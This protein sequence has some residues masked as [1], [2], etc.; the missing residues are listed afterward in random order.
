MFVLGFLL[1][2]NAQSTISGQNNVLSGPILASEPVGGG[3]ILFQDMTTGRTWGLWTPVPTYDVFPT[4]WSSDGCNIVILNRR[5]GEWGTLSIVNMI[6]SMFPELPDQLNIVSTP[7]WH[8]D[9]QHLTLTVQDSVDDSVEILL[10][11]PVTQSIDVLYSSEERVNPL[12]W[13]SPTELLSSSVD[14]WFVWNSVNGQNTSFGTALFPRN[15]I[16]AEDASFMRSQQRS[17]NF[18][19]VTT[20]YTIRSYNR[21]IW[22]GEYDGLTVDEINELDEVYRQTGFDLYDLN[23]GTSKHIDVH[24]EFLQAQEW[25][26]SGEHIVVSTYADAGTE[27][28]TIYVY[29]LAMDVL[30]QVGEFPAL[31]DIEYGSYVPTWSPDEQ[32]LAINTLDGWVTYNLLTG[33]IINLNVSHPNAY[34]SAFTNVYMRLSWSPIMDYANSICS[35]DVES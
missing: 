12:A 22:E 9:G 13:L 30:T 20:Y 34:T 5:T 10:L 3:G 25:S 28:G 33:E 32:W 4:R 6:I 11:N 35:A 16:P 8:P 19:Y 1:L 27:P 7:L 17:P 29:D 24:G 18:E 15:G 23:D 14:G 2:T 31:F 26:P 21:A